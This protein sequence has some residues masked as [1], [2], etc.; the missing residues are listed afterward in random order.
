MTFATQTFS[1]GCE[2]LEWSSWGFAT[3]SLRGRAEGKRRRYIWGKVFKY[4]WEKYLSIFINSRLTKRT[5]ALANNLTE[6][7]IKKETAQ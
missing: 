7:K 5:N 1:T 6:T 2:L 4:L 3:S